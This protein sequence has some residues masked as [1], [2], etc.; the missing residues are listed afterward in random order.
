MKG[1]TSLADEQQATTIGFLSRAVAWFN[2]Q[3]AECR[4]VM[5][6]NGS[7]YIC[8]VFANA[9]SILKLKH[10][11]TRPYTPRTNGKADRFIQILCKDGHMQCRSRTPRSGCLAIT[12]LVNLLPDQEVLSPRR[13]IPSAAAP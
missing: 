8:K 9:S 7:A 12:L 10:I 4:Q 13:S 6:D 2:G 1:V 11:G 5:S 3:G